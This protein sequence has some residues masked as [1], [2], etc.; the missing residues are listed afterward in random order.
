[1]VNARESFADSLPEGRLRSRRI[2]RGFAL[3]GQLKR[4]RLF[5]YIAAEQEHLSAERL[6]SR[7]KWLLIL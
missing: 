7:G 5:F 3:G 1:M 4:S 6:F 2:R